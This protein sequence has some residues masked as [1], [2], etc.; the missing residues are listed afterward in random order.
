MMN[1][2]SEYGL[3]L[4]R[5]AININLT[6]AEARD[7]SLP[8]ISCTYYR[9]IILQ[10][11]SRVRKSF[12]VLAFVRRMRAEKFS[13]S[14]SLFLSPPPVRRQTARGVL[15]KP[16]YKQALRQIHKV[17]FI[18]R[19]LKAG[20]DAGRGGREARNSGVTD[21]RVKLSG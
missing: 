16:S 3:R 12:L 15:T 14:L 13:L 4:T 5:R 10:T 1:I 11:R 21:R 2:K 17:Q 9:Q 18:N 6:V 7:K 20:W 8:S 19:V